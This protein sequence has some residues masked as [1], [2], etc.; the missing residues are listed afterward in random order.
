MS[1]ERVS[2]TETAL[3]GWVGIMWLLMIISWLL[4]IGMIIIGIVMCMW[5]AILLVWSVWV[6]W[7]HVSTKHTTTTGIEMQATSN[8]R[9]ANTNNNFN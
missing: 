1:K 2:D 8:R 9:E 5:A 4:T 3:V 6:V 7:K